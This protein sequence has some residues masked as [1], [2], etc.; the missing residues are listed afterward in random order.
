MPASTRRTRLLQ[1]RSPPPRPRNP[2]QCVVPTSSWSMAPARNVSAA[3][4]STDILFALRTR[5]LP[6]E[7]CLPALFTPTTRMTVG[8]DPAWITRD[9]C[10]RSAEKS[11]FLF[12]CVELVLGL[13]ETAARLTLDLGDEAWSWARRSRPRAAPLP[14]S[15]GSPDGAGSNDRADIGQRNV[16]IWP[17]ANGWASPARRSILLG[18]HWH[19]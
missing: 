13:D 14:V 17:T 15:R 6:D 2:L 10:C 11:R 3:P 9:R 12:Q 19:G 16:F 8:P 18:I 4:T 7:G 5:E 1:G